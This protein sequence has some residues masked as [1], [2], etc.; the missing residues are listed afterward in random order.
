MNTLTSIWVYDIKWICHSDD[1]NIKTSYNDH[2]KLS[3]LIIILL[4]ILF[5]IVFESA[6]IAEIDST[7]YSNGMKSKM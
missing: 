6:E 1:V 3:S 7:L 4:E 5:S 2:D